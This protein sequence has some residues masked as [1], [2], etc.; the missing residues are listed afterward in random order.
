MDRRTDTLET[1]MTAY[2]NAA[3]AALTIKALRTIAKEHGVKQKQPKADLIT[4][5]I[6]ATTP[7]TAPDTTPDTTPDTNTN[8]Q[9]STVAPDTAFNLDTYLTT[10]SIDAAIVVQ[11]LIG[12]ASANGY[13][14]GFMDEAR[15]DSGFSQHKFAGHIANLDTVIDW[16]CDLSQDKG[17]A[18][19]EIQFGLIEAL[20]SDEA[21]NTVSAFIKANAEDGVTLTAPTEDD[22]PAAP[23]KAKWS[24][25]TAHVSED[26]Q[27]AAVAQVIDILNG[28]PT[29]KAA[30]EAIAAI[31]GTVKASAIQGRIAT[32]RKNGL[33]TVAKQDDTDTRPNATVVLITADA[34]AAAKALLKIKA[35]KAAPAATTE[36]DAKAAA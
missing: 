12:A 35:P 14:F 29:I 27:A 10:I 13:D 34:E 11:S 31:V 17:T 8:T 26:D 23:V 21:Y 9:E 2:T 33:I 24:N 22:A 1:P 32:Q 7:D 30:S 3:L 20:N 15:D 18:C 4:A 36:D 25:K 16:S 5:I 19:N 6:A 28:K